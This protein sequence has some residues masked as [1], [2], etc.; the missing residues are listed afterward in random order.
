MINTNQHYEKIYF[1]SQIILVNRGWVPKKFVKTETRV[2]GNK[3]G[4]T[5]LVGV[6]RKAEGRPQFAPKSTSDQLLYR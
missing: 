5:E 2:D 1:R 3:L 6:V 4:V